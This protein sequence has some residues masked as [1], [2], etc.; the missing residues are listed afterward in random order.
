VT[1]LLVNMKSET[2]S[3]PWHCV[4]FNISTFKGDGYLYV[5]LALQRPL[6]YYQGFQFIR[7]R[8]N[9]L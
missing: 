6:G 3:G 2:A 9:N 4:V 8:Q 1:K 7:C 5:K